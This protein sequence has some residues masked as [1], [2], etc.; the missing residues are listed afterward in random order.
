MAEV[1]PFRGVRYSSP[2]LNSLLCPPYDVIDPPLAAKLRRR[3]LNAIFLEL[4]QGKTPAKYNRAAVRWR[5]WIQ[6]GTLL[7]DLKPAFYVIEERY[8]FARK[9]L[10]RRGLLAALAAKPKTIIAHERTLAKPRADRLQMLDA[11]GVNISPIFGVFSDRSGAARR[12]IAAAMKDRPNAAGR[13][14]ALVD[15]R[16]WVV[17]EPK[18]IKAL[19]RALAPCSILIA[20]G[21]HR[22]CVSR[23]QHARTPGPGTDAV[24]A[25]LV[26]DEDT[27]LV[28]LPTHRIAKISLL[29]RAGALA[30]LRKMKNLSALEHGLAHSKNPYAFGLIEKGFH[31]GEPKPNGCGSGLAVEWLREQLLAEVKPEDLSYTPDARLAV[32]KAKACGGAAVLVKPFTVSQ[33]R[34]AAQAVGLLPQKSTFFYPKITT[35]LAFRP[36]DGQ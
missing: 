27:G 6:D 24:L 31:L 11:V 18:S 19:R 2:I 26:P 34:R 21:H 10:I 13:S 33:V 36:L 8:Q 23:D 25:Y 16:L 20:D 9:T 17:D 5:R 3:R 28:V 1:R 12:A 32:K 30:P 29:K 22:Y 15:Y 4:P 35:G 7:R 14:H